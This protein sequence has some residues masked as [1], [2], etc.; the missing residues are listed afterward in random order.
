MKRNTATPRYAAVSVGPT[1]SQAT[2]RLRQLKART[3]FIAGPAAATKTRPRRRQRK[4]AGSTG[5]T[6]QAIP[7][8][9]NTINDIPPMWTIGLAVIR[10]RRL[11]VSSPCQ[12]AAHPWANS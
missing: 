6:P 2:K 10:C 9:R 11:G 4:R 3:R 5:M 7:M 1:A 12:M 8:S